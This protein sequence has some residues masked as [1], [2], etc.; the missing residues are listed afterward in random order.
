MRVPG[1]D[2]SARMARVL[3]SP[4]CSNF[5]SFLRLKCDQL[6]VGKKTRAQQ[7][8]RSQR[9]C[10]GSASARPGSRVI[11]RD[12]GERLCAGWRWTG[13]SRFSVLRCV[14]YCPR[15]QCV[16]DAAGNCRPLPAA[17]G[18]RTCQ[19]PLPRAARRTVVT[20][21][22]VRI[23]LGVLVRQK[24]IFSSLSCLSTVA[25]SFRSCNVS[26]S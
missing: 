15:R 24:L 18:L 6:T 9:H 10:H 26:S 7:M 11:L 19:G 20:C 22:T 4:N 2:V 12:V 16:H 17:P 5:D 3:P 21:A 1:E 23:E 14:G 25:C 13:N 8:A